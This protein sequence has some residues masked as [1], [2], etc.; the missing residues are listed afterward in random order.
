MALWHVLGPE[1]ALA[2]SQ[3]CSEPGW[4]S[5]SNPKTWWQEAYQSRTAYRAYT[6]PENPSVLIVDS[7]N[8]FPARFIMCRLLVRVA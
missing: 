7:A 1:A 3:N 2:S 6:A 8:S 5:A 4:P